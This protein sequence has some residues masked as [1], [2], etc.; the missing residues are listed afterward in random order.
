M[1]PTGMGVEPTLRQYAFGREWNSNET[2]GDTLFLKRLMKILFEEL[3]NRFRCKEA[4]ST[5]VQMLDCR[6]IVP[7]F[8]LGQ[9]CLL[10]STIISTH[11]FVHIFHYEMLKFF[12]RRK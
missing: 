7:T 4:A 1:T 12:F 5:A 6:L 2:F 10:Y 11:N 3:K 9:R 8:V